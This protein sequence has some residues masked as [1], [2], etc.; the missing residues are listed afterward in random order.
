LRYSSDLIRLGQFFQTDKWGIHWYLQ[1]YQTHF[2]PLRSKR[3]N[4]LEIGVGG[5]DDPAQGGNSLRTWKAYF[6]HANIIGID[7]HDKRRLEEPRIRIFQGDQVDEGFLREVVK[8]SGGLDL[9]IDD[10]SHV[11]ADVIRTFE[12]LFPLMNR[13]GIYVVE[14]TQTSYWPGFG[15]SSCKINDPRTIM[16]YF[17]SLCHSLNFQEIPRDN[18]SPTD[19]DRHVVAAHFYHNLIFICKGDNSET[20]NLSQDANV[21]RV[22]FEGPGRQHDARESAVGGGL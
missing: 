14:D 1:H 15:G 7:I 21:A 12:I 6:P 11:N 13:P 18:Y 20:S 9:V 2:A 3:L 22:A 4:L 8:Q 5:Y 16:G 10:G 17:T 19:F